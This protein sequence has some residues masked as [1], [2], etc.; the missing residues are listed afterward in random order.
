MDFF[1]E[2]IVKKKKNAQDIMTIIVT[3]MAAF[4]ILY[5]ILIQ[6]SL[7]SLVVLIPIELALV[8]FGVYAVISSLNVEFEYSV[9]N[10]DLDID[11]ITSKKRRKRLVSIKL[12]DVEYFERLNDL[13]FSVA[14]DTSVNTVIDASSSIDS[15]NVYFAIYYN[16]SGKVCLLFEPTEKMI[17]NFAH[18]IP[19]ALNYTL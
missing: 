13:H 7:G 9:T 19:R 1:N 2:W 3:V 12:R 18:Y 5:L 8:V 17:E 14:E 10:G 11:K 15:P 16:N 4:L 6:F